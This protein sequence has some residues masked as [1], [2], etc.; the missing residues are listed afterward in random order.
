M[1]RFYERYGHV[2]FTLLISILAIALAYLSV[3]AVANWKI[4]PSAFN[5]NVLAIHDV[6]VA[7]LNALASLVAKHIQYIG[8]LVTLGTFIF[9]LTVG[10]RQAKRQPP[11]RLIEFMREQLTP[12]YDN[13]EALVAAVTHRSASVSERKPLYLKHE[14]DRAL[15]ALGGGWRPRQ[16]QS[17]DE[18][19]TEAETYIE[20]TEKRLQYLKDIRSHAQTLRGAVRSYE[21][22]TRRS[23]E[24]TQIENDQSVEA[25]FTLAI[26]N[27]T[28]KVATGTLQLALTASG[29]ASAR[30]VHKPRLLS[31]AIPTD[32]SGLSWLNSGASVGGRRKYLIEFHH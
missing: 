9:G 28:T 12:V 19:I 11:R 32:D 5:D 26:E 25:D 1:S 3:V 18:S 20:T 6:V 29:C 7:I 10:I 17:L 27:A 23:D 4:L 31:G 15:D 22:L 14:L 13:T 21:W 2:I 16:K 8:A 30:V 24:D